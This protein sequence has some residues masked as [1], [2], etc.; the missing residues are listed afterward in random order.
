MVNPF[1]ASKNKLFMK[2]DNITDKWKRAALDICAFP[3]VRRSDLVIIGSAA[4]FASGGYSD[5]WHIDRDVL[6]K[7]Y[8]VASPNFLP[9]TPHVMNR[10]L[11][12]YEAFESH[13]AANSHRKYPLPQIYGRET[14]DTARKEGDACGYAILEKFPGQPITLTSFLDMSSSQKDDWVKATVLE[15]IQFERV[16]TEVK[17]PPDFWFQSYFLPRIDMIRNDMVGIPVEDLAIL[18]DLEKILKDSI[19]DKRPILGHGD[20][21]FDNI[22]TSTNEKGGLI[23][24]FVDPNISYNSPEG[25]YRKLMIYPDLGLACAELHGKLT[26]TRYDPAVMLAYGAFTAHFIYCSRLHMDPEGAAQWADRRDECLK[27]LKKLSIQV[28]N[29][30]DITH[31]SAP[32]SSELEL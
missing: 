22:I 10:E 13:Y 5:I 7:I 23:C 21:A 11:E 25:S 26:G 17:S 19:N 3:R 32:A 6:A 16:L 14:I 2:Q 30:L 8:R 12:T 27:R 28:V 31:T 24:R 1:V 9:A 20:L 29:T 18:D 15:N 4:F